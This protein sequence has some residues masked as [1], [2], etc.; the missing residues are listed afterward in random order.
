MRQHAW[1]CCLSTKLGTDILTN[2]HIPGGWCKAVTILAEMQAGRPALIQKDGGKMLIAIVLDK[3]V[4]E[5]KALIDDPAAF[6]RE[7]TGSCAK[8]RAI[9]LLP[10]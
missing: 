1:N 7:M 5:A 3:P 6:T 9:H 2:R 4:A 8:N 10:K